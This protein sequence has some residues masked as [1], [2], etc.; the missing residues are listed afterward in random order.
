MPA[1]RKSRK[2]IPKGNKRERTRARLLEAALEV[3]R[4]K[5]L[6]RTTLDDVA[7]KAGLSRGAIYGNFRDKDELFVALVEAR[8]RPVTPLKHGT[9][10]KEHLR[11]VGETVVAAVPARRAQALGALSL[12]IYA[13]GHEEVRSKIVELN[14]DFYRRGA[15]R[16]EQLLTPED[17]P[18]PPDQLVRVLHALS[19]GL[20]SL[21]LLQPELITDELIVAAFDAL[22]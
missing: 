14:A 19:D 16:L 1:K 22:A 3:I 17:L 20:L 21:R 6:F 4:Q 13:L 10:L 7:A 15:E 11:L 12:Q 2:G 5:G 18:M 9:T 8:W